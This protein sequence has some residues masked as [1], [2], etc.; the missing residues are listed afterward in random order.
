MEQ[1][2]KHSISWAARPPLCGQGTTALVSH[3]RLNITVSSIHHCAFWGFS[4]PR[5]TM[6]QKY[7]MENSRNKKFINFNL[8]AA[9]SSLMKPVAVLV[10]QLSF[11]PAYMP[12]DTEKPSGLSDQLPWYRRICVQVTLILLNNTKVH[13]QFRSTKI[14]HKVFP[15]KWKR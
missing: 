12:G 7:Y 3:F 6:V 5:S 8:C 14:S 2:R 1:R 9:L 13:G 4:N 10:C 15:F 11:C